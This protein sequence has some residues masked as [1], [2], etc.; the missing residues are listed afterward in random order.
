M[1]LLL[2]ETVLKEILNKNYKE[3]LFL[4]KV[5][6]MASHQSNSENNQAAQSPTEHQ[7]SSA[8]QTGKRKIANLDMCLSEVYRDH[9]Q[10]YLMQLFAKLVNT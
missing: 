3:L 8:I 5:L 7:T 1:I 2:N 10:M 6:D 4:L 9:C